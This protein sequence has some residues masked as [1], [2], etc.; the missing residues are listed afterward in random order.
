[1]T[2]DSPIPTDDPPSADRSRSRRW[3]VAIVISL[4]AFLVM[5]H[6]VR[7]TVD[8]VVPPTNFGV[9]GAK[10]DQYR[11][12]KA[13]LDTL[14]LGTSR[15]LYGIN[16]SIFDATMAARGCPTR[17]FNLSLRGLNIRELILLVRA[18]HDDPP[19]RLKYLLVEPRPN[20][21]R[22]LLTQRFQAT[23]TPDTFVLSVREIFINPRRDYNKMF[24]LRDYLL[25]FTYRNIGIGAIHNYLSRRRNNTSGTEADDV[26][27]NST[28]RP[29]GQKDDGTIE[30]HA[31][32]FL[33]AE[34]RIAWIRYLEWYRDHAEHRWAPGQLDG[35]LYLVNSFVRTLES[36]SGRV[37][38][39]L[40]PSVY[41]Q[42]AVVKQ[43]FEQ[44]YQWL[45]VVAL[46]P[47]TQPD[48]YD[49]KLWY[50][51]EHL[52]DVG[53]SLYSRRLAEA[54]CR[55]P[56]DMGASTTLMPRSDRLL[57]SD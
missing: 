5:G 35:W 41:T 54:I 33:S 10:L 45:L 55:T 49:A 16:P 34:H 53:A 23:L 1:M 11:S 25:A 4:L 30:F 17:S 32:E 2:M 40:P 29:L 36:I 6:L 28:Y 14:F 3:V 48:L 24:A 22:A 47:V 12:L 51:D 21:S 50:D 7:R 27:D 26:A 31:P 8:A 42:T 13:E 20:Q 18:I 19:P 52:N 57:G 15:L 9:V 43:V 39:V 44:Y 56:D 37:I 38:I 46:D